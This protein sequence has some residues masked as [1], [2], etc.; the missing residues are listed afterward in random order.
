MAP[1]AAKITASGE[2]RCGK[3]ARVIE[4]GHFLQSVDFH[5]RSLL[6]R[7]KRNLPAFNAMGLN[8]F[9]FSCCAWFEFVITGRQG[10]DG[11]SP[12]IIIRFL[13]SVFSKR[14]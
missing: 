12:S 3:F 1:G 10:K 13:N 11:W 2:N 8:G 7:I 5:A 4:Q 14:R 6:I 9:N